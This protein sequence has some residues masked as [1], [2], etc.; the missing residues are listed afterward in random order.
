M[1]KKKVF[2]SKT[3][4]V[5]AIALVAMIVQGFTGKEIISLEMQATALS[6]INIILRLITKEAVE[7]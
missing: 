7:W 4:W 6:V 3:F 5:N 1:G 2:A